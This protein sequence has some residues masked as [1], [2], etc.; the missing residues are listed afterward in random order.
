VFQ[1]NINLFQTEGAPRKGCDIESDWVSTQYAEVDP[2]R[3]PV[4]GMF[5]CPDQLCKLLMHQVKVEFVD[6]T[7]SVQFTEMTGWETVGI[8]LSDADCQLITGVVVH[9]NAGTRRTLPCESVVVAAGAWSG[10]VLN[11]FRQESKLVPDLSVTRGTTVRVNDFLP[12]NA[13]PVCMFANSTKGKG[14]TRSLV[15]TRAEIYYR[16]QT[17]IAVDYD[18][19]YKLTGGHSETALVEHS[20][21]HVTVLRD[22]LKKLLTADICRNHDETDFVAGACVYGSYDTGM[23]IIDRVPCFTNAFASYAHGE[24]GVLLGPWSSGVLASLIVEGES[25]M[26]TPTQLA[27]FS[28]DLCLLS[29]YLSIYGW[30]DGWMDG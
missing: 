1:Q 19:E 14:S 25:S 16:N 12:S 27:H 6:T 15:Q 4:S 7:R 10:K 11:T 28:F 13:V 18:H 20:Q 9:N 2:S 22:V 5:A 29:I 26:L 21:R 24:W 8:Q 3:T 30:M 17:L 23:P